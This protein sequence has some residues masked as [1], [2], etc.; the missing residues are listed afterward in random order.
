[1]ASLRWLVEG[2]GY[3]ITGLDVW[4]AYSSTLKAAEHAGLVDETRRRIEALVAKDTSGEGFVT[5]VLGRE[6]GLS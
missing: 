3:E 1:M 5:K 4:N 2:Y 6:L